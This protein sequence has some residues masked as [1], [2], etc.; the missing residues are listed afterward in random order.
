MSKIVLLIIFNEKIFNENVI[1][2]FRQSH[3]VVLVF[4]DKFVSE[5]AGVNFAYETLIQIAFP[6]FKLKVF[7]LYKLFLVR[8]SSLKFN[9]I[10]WALL[11]GVGADVQEV[12]FW[13]ALLLLDSKN[14]IT[15]LKI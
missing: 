2:C 15:Y 4:V 9:I 8:V 5:F 1:L 6:L 14:S 11:K 10:G 13:A 3:A 12:N 7:Y